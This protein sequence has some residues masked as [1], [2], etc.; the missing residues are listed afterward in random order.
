MAKSD[1]IFIT[2]SEFRSRYQY[3]PKDLLGEGGFAQVYKAYDKQFQ[4]YVALKFYNKADE[5]KYDVLHEMKDARMFSHPNIVRVHDAFIVKFEHTGTVSYTQVGAMEYANGGNLRNFIETS[6]SEQRFIK[7]LIEILEAL[8]YLHSNKNII[9]RDLSP[10]NILMFIEGDNWIPKIAD[11]GISKKISITAATKDANKSTQLVGKIEYMAPE[12]FS[13]ERFGI[14]KKI[15]TNVDIWSFGIILY[16]LFNHKTPFGSDVI[17]SPMNI[18]Q[19]ITDTP[20]PSLKDIP[21]PY[22]TVI[23]KCLVKDANHRA[24]SAKDLIQILESAQSSDDAIATTVPII[25]NRNK[26]RNN[27][28]LFSGIA[29]AIIIAAVAGVMLF[30]KGAHHEISKTASANPDDA[31]AGIIRLISQKKYDLALTEINALPNEYR[32]QAEFKELYTQ[33]KTQISFDSLMS[34]GDQLMTGKKYAE[35]NFVYQKLLDQYKPTD[36]QYKYLKNQLSLIKK[37]T[38]APPEPAPNPIAGTLYTM[39]RITIKRAPEDNEIE[40]VSVTITPQNTIIKLKL[41][42]TDEKMTLYEPGSD[43]AFFLEFNKRTQQLPLLKIGGIRP[44]EI[45]GLEKDK[46]FDLYFDRLPDGVKEFSLLEGKERLNEG[47]NYWNFIGI[48]LH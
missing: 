2:E 24:K 16:E 3:G 21:E 32:S 9:H 35:A 45:N 25:E 40:F 13:P 1:E 15:G 33:C 34:V 46:T 30:G 6:P 47:M 19:R 22:C 43:K 18:M 39:D 41:R 11:F 31:K 38:S 7:V 27:L 4:E 26:K 17:E 12:Q 8:K 28:L 44:G 20:I 14:D 5:G 36:D 29:A 10:E 48:D 23:K 37:N 42:A